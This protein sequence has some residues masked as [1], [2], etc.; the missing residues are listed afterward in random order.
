MRWTVSTIFMMC[1]Y[2]TQYT[3]MLSPVNWYCVLWKNIVSYHLI[4]GNL[5]QSNLYKASVP[6][7]C[8]NTEFFW[9]VF[10]RVWTEYWETLFSLNA[11]KYGPELTPYLDTI[12]AVHHC[13]IDLIFCV[14]IH[15]AQ[16]DLV[17]RLIKY[18]C[19]L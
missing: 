17:L 6:E 13:A 12:H 18:H 15:I 14:I 10:S 5:I 9:S 2:I 4:L 7:K 16:Y 1:F 3:F 8:P 11:G 19:I